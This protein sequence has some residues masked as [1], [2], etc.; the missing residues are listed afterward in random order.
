MAYTVK[1]WRD[2][3]DTSTPIT[4]AAIED[5][6]SRLS[7]YTATHLYFNVKDYGAVGDGTTDD[8][9]AILNAATA[10]RNAGGA[11]CV[12]FP[13]SSGAYMIGQALPLDVSYKGASRVVTVGALTALGSQTNKMLFDDGANMTKQGRHL[14]DLTLSGNN[15]SGVQ[16]VSSSQGRLGNSNGRFEN[17]Y[18]ISTATNVYAVGPS[19]DTGS[20]NGMFGGATFLSCEWEACPHALW[21]GVTSDDVAVINCRFKMSTTTGGGIGPFILMNAGNIS[22]ICTW[23]QFGSI[24]NYTALGGAK[25]IFQTTGTGPL[26]IDGLNLEAVGMTTDVTHIIFSQY[27]HVHWRGGAMG[28]TTQP[29]LTALVR[30]E[31]LPSDYCGVAVHGIQGSTGNPTCPVFDVNVYDTASTTTGLVNLAFSGVDDWASL[32]NVTGTDGGNPI[33]MNGTYRRVAY[34]G[35]TNKSLW[36]T[37]NRVGQRSNGWLEGAEITDPGAPPANSGNLFFR[38]NG[39][40]KTQLVA[41][42][43]T[44]AVQVIS[45]EP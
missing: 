42:F 28:G 1:D 25:P 27:S 17:L 40:G 23:L 19:A 43:P 11:G 10:A 41:R 37:G 26:Y 35:Y 18:F 30:T 12:Y 7:A 3:P 16:L 32:M 20:G 13:H 15:V 31:A 14:R 21:F 39:S 8:A 45:T 5:M 34:N 9:P 22:F 44:G 38:D 29:T 36:N 33:S 2:F 24:G 4:A 6:E